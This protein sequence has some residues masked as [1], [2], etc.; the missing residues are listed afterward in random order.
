M[1]TT[2]MRVSNIDDVGSAFVEA[3]EIC[4]LHGLDWKEHV[5]PKYENRKIVGYYVLDETR[6]TTITTVEI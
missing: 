4:R 1:T 3:L 5:M 6:S 2:G